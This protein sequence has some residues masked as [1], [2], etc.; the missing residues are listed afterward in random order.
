VIIFYGTDIQRS[1]LL[2]FEKIILFSLMQNPSE[3]IEIINTQIPTIHQRPIGYRFMCQF[4]SHTVFHHP[5][6]KTNYD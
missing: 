6:I 5:L 1:T 2:I 4:W 3:T